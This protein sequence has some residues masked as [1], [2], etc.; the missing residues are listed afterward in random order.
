MES[1]WSK[2][3][4]IPQGLFLVLLQGSLLF[5]FGLIFFVAKRR[6]NRKGKAVA[7][8]GT[9]AA[10]TANDHTL[11]FTMEEKSA[12]G[13]YEELG[14]KDAGALTDRDREE[15][16]ILA[17]RADLMALESNYAANQEER[18]EAFWLKL[19]QDMQTLLDRHDLYG[20]LKLTGEDENG[21]RKMM[22]NQ[23]Q[24]IES[25]QAFAAKH[26]ADEDARQNLENLFGSLQQQSRE[27]GDCVTVLEDENEF[28]RAQIESLLRQD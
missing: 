13:R 1:V 12:R 18:S 4:E 19:Y 2:M 23:H 20:R 25:L 26:I 15:Q 16:L 27:L 22:Q 8:T 6:R 28:L 11:Y 17:L 10:D 3:V 14:Y 9:P 5:L 24:S 21:F 7:E